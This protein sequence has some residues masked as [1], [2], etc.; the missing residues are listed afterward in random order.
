MRKLKLQLSETYAC[1]LCGSFAASNFVFI[2]GNFL[3]SFQITTKLQRSSD[4]ENVHVC[5]RTF[6]PYDDITKTGSCQNNDFLKRIFLL[7][8][9]I[10]DT[11][12]F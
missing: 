8:S 12:I 4:F 7:N 3:D 6:R 5:L 1:N 9:F 10:C 11:T 2:I